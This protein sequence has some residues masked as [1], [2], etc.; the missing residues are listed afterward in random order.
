MEISFYHFCLHF[1]GQ[2]SLQIDPGC[3]LI[4]AVLKCP[5]RYIALDKKGF[6][7]II[8]LFL[9]ENIYCGYSLEVV[10]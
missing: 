3:V 10:Q 5:V 8:F 7:F 1:V 9:L 2:N 6:S 4:A